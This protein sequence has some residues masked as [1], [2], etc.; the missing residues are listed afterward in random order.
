MTL[1][2]VPEVLQE[3][4]VNWGGISEMSLVS[5]SFEF[6]WAMFGSAGDSISDEESKILPLLSTVPW[7]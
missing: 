2:D 7:S 3:L 4:Y 1:W 5:E 6:A